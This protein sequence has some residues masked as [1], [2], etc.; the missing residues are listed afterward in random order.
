ME[1]ETV[2]PV[3]VHGATDTETFVGSQEATGRAV[4]ATPVDEGEQVNAGVGDFADFDDLKK[5]G[6]GSGRRFARGV[7][8]LA[9]IV[10]YQGD[11]GGKGAVLAFCDIEEDVETLLMRRVQLLES[12]FKGYLYCGL[13]FGLL[14][15]AW[16]RLQVRDIDIRSLIDDKECRTCSM[17]SFGRHWKDILSVWSSLEE[18]GETNWNAA[19]KRRVG[20]LSIGSIPNVWGFGCLADF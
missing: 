17:A 18:K 10:S 16:S 4:G 14:M 9:G 5:Q 6:E 11:G 2:Q 12:G 7:D 8:G 15:I 1:S 19:K 3:A 13:T 20:G